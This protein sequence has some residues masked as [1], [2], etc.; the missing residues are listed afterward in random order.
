MELVRRSAL[1]MLVLVTTSTSMAILAQP[2][3]QELVQQP[4]ADC[5]LV[6]LV[7]YIVV[8]IID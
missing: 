2:F 4:A 5:L 6:L 1:A 3:L 7:S 8:L